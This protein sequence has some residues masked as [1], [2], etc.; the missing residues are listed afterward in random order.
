MINGNLYPV[1]RQKNAYYVFGAKDYEIKT[2]KMH[3]FLISGGAA[4]YVGSVPIS[5]KVVM[6]LRMYNLDLETG[7]MD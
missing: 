3:I 4:G 5:Q 7:E 6:K 1:L 2:Y